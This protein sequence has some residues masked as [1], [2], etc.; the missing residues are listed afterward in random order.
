MSI[1]ALFCRV[2]FLVIFSDDML[3][4]KR[5]TP[6]WSSRR[7]RKCPKA[8]IPG[9][10]CDAERK[11]EAGVFFKLRK[12]THDSRRG[13]KMRNPCSWC[14][15]HVFLLVVS[16]GLI[17]QNLNIKKG[18]LN[19]WLYQ[20]WCLNFEPIIISIM[21]FAPAYD[22]IYYVLRPQLIKIRNCGNNQCNIVWWR[23]GYAKTECHDH[24][25]FPE[26]WAGGVI[27]F[28]VAQAQMHH[29]SRF[30]GRGYDTGF[31]SNA[32][33]IATYWKRRH[34]LFFGGVQTHCLSRLISNTTFRGVVD[35][36]VGI[37]HMMI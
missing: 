30:T 7:S 13:P 36:G 31:S 1:F 5:S 16:T 35:A 25:P 29:S 9:M 10:Q 14:L 12:H 34:D 22:H 21:C 28:P 11:T 24:R 27:V 15:L 33:Q 2:I 18:R 37:H 32:F 17:V 19:V 20:R 8:T 26:G 6:V 3:N 4:E 23:A